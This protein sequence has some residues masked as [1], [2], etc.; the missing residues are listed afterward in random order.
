MRNARFCQYGIQAEEKE[1]QGLWEK[2]KKPRGLW[3][4]YPLRCRGY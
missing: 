4:A 3:L 1:W 2:G